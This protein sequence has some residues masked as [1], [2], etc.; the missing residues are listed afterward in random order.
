MTIH[1]LR[2]L[3]V[4]MSKLKSMS[5]SGWIVVGFL[6]A[7][8]VVP[9]GVAVAKALTYNGIEDQ[10]GNRALVEP[11]GQL[12]T[13]N[14]PPNTVFANQPIE[15]LSNET[16]INQNASGYDSVIT[17]ISVDFS[18]VDTGGDSLV[19]YLSPPGSNCNTSGGVNP[20]FVDHVIRIVDA[21]QIG[22][23]EITFPSGLPEPNNQLLCGVVETPSVYYGLSLNGVANVAIAGYGV[24]EGTFSG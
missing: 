4:E 18:E 6:T 23:T 16:Q 7:L 11:D 1:L 17:S 5:R 12:Y 2:K 3:E 19:I 10:N 13:T 8:L 9:S 14:A 21:A 20:D 22:D 24:P 15:V